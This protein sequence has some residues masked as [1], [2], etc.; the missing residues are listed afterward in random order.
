MSQRW[1][2]G[3]GERALRR[4]NIAWGL[5]LSLLL[6]A[7]VAFLNQRDPQQYNEVLLWSVVGF[8]ALANLVNYLRYRRWL[9]RSAEHSLELRDDRLRFS[10]ADE[11]SVLEL[12]QVTALRVFRRSGQL[13]HIQLL[14]PNNRGIRLEGYD[15]LDGLLRALSERLPAAKIMGE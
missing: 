9:R 15:D 14:L 7:M 11:E 13:R 6:A 4:R 12:D 1:T 8:V 2:I 5:L 3:T 10:T